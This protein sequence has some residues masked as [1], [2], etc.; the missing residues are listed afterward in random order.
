M[1]DVKQEG[2]KQGRKDVQ[3]ACDYRWF[4]GFRSFG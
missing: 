3:Y 4:L 2:K 1:E